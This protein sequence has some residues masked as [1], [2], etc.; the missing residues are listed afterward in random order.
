MRK[1]NASV[2]IRRSTTARPGGP[3]AVSCGTD[4]LF[5]ININ[6]NNITSIDVPTGEGIATRRAADASEVINSILSEGWDFHAFSTTFVVQSGRHRT[7][8]QCRGRSPCKDASSAPTSSPGDP[9][10]ETVR[11]PIGRRAAG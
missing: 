6:L 3:A 4:L 1:K 2:S 8:A 7:A 10:A 9:E 5:Q 11:S